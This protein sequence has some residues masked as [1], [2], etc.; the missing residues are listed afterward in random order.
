MSDTKSAKV[1]AMHS[2]NRWD[3]Q[4]KHNAVVRNNPQRYE[5]VDTP[6]FWKGVDY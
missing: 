3:D 4:D 6:N 1:I 2:C 5:Y